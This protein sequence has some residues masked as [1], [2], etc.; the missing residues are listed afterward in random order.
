MPAPE[1]GGR[2][3]SYLDIA[4]NFHPFLLSCHLPLRL[5]GWPSPE[6]FWGWLGTVG[7]QGQQF[8]GEPASW[9]GRGG[10]GGV[11]RVRNTKTED[12]GFRRPHMATPTTPYIELGFGIAPWGSWWSSREAAPLA[13]GGGWG[14]RSPVR[15]E[16]LLPA[17]SLLLC[18]ALFQGLRPSN[19][20]AP[21]PA[22]PRPL[23][24]GAQ[25]CAM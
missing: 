16:A 14:G 23:P 4:D 18:N 17:P 6:C 13:A 1:G 21:A 20:Q 7:P 12:Y 5:Q 9:G 8:R 11:G 19:S 22:W 10:R 15:R 3:C 2:G 24:G 25:P